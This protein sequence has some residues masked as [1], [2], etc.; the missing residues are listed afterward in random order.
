MSYD[1]IQLMDGILWSGKFYYRDVM[2]ITIT[3]IKG[4]GNGNFY[5]I[6]WS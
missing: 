3:W 4:E 2:K 5:H 1:N 6:L